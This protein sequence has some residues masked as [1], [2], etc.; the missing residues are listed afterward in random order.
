MEIYIT[1]IKMKNIFLFILLF[2]AKQFCQ[3]DSLCGKLEKEYNSLPIDVP[4]IMPKLLC[5]QD[6]I[7][8]ILHNVPYP[9]GIKD[10]AEGRIFISF[11]VDTDGNPKCFKVIMGLTTDLDNA[12]IKLLKDMNLKFTPAVYNHKKVPVKMVL[13]VHYH[14]RI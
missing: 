12:A 13:Q 11:I 2:S 10:S 5:N 3:T 4:M 6:S 14:K 1:S 8:N 7:L 9:A